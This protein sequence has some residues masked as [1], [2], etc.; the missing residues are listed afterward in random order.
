MSAGDHR[1]DDTAADVPADY[2][3]RTRALVARARVNRTFTIPYL[4]NRSTDGKRVYIDDSVPTRVAGVLTGRTLPWHE[5]SEWLAMNDGMSY[6]DAHRTVANPVERKRVE[7]LGGNWHD[8]C[9]AFGPLIRRVDDEQIT[10]VPSDIDLRP[11][12]DEHDR[13]AMAE[14]AGS[15]KEPEAR[16]MGDEMRKKFVAAAIDGSS[17]S[18]KRQVLVNCSADGVDRQG[19]IV[20]QGG[21]DFQSFMGCGGTVLWQH[22]A[23]APIAKAISIGLDGG[24]LRSLVQFPD[25]GI[26]P[27]SDEIYGL[28]RAGV[29]N[30]TSIGFQPKE[31]E[32]IDPKNPWGGQKFKQIELMEF[33]FVSVPAMPAATVIAR[34]NKGGDG[35]NWKCGASRN[36]PIGDDAAWDG[37]AA[38]ASIWEHCGMDGDDPDTSFCRKGFLVYDAADPSKKGSYKLP[39]AKVVDGRLT[40]MPSGIRA[41]ASRLPQTDCSA[42]AKDKA[43]AV[44]DH[45]E[46]K[47]KPDDGKGLPAKF[48][49]KTIVDWLKTEEA[50]GQIVWLLRA[51]HDGRMLDEEAASRISDMQKCVKAMCELHKSA[52]D[53][54]GQT[55]D[56]LQ[57]FADHL[58]TFDRHTKFL[59]KAAR[60]PPPH[61][62]P[63][64]DEG[65]D[66]DNT[67]AA[68]EENPDVELAAAAR[69]KRIVE[70]LALSAPD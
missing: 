15:I 23:N 55:H 62:E 53:S 6:Q 29:I 19:D 65:A 32:P 27:K 9:A 66:A 44:I 38:E 10:K 24:Q 22:D 39:F 13:A 1:H 54:H 37:P 69:R 25:A 28:I 68:D 11:Y 36:L 7:Q 20:V 42:D 56:D 67:G 46:E 12:E 26:S 17:L 47:M 3:E 57:N 2:W 21:I 31:W 64:G 48:D 59:A 40:A 63:D 49:R 4:A 52:M 8:Y 5:L 43:R 51:A 58:N 61:D 50:F 18:D 45:Y 70:V 33:S 41:A 30:T 14:L 35:A 60:K 34:T 16:H